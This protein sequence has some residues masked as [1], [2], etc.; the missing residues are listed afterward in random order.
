VKDGSFLGIT[1]WGGDAVILLPGVH[2][3]GYIVRVASPSG[4]PSHSNLYARGEIASEDKADLGTEFAK[5]IDELID[6]LSQRSK[7]LSSAGRAEEAEVLADLAVPWLRKEAAQHRAASAR[8]HFL[9]A[10][11][12]SA[13][14]VGPKA[15][16]TMSELARN[17]YTDR[18]NLTRT[19]NQ[20][21]AEETI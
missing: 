17:L 1:G 13:G 21:L 7:D 19:I 16:I 18:G 15:I 12:P 11:D 5:A 9:A 4:D 2:G 10:A 14:L 6:D 20:A 8:Q 3:G